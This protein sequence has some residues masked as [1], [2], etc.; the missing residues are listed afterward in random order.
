MKRTFQP[1]KHTF[2]PMKRTFQALERTF[3]LIEETI[4]V[5]RKTIL[6]VLEEKMNKE[7]TLRT[8]KSLPKRFFYTKILLPLHRDKCKVRHCCGQE[9]CEQI[10]E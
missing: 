7:G 8:A 4:S 10:Y 1:M 2:Q 9:V 3:Q 5:Y 6:L